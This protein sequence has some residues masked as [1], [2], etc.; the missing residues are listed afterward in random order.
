MVQPLVETISGPSYKWIFGIGSL[1]VGVVL[2]QHLVCEEWIFS[3]V[4]MKHK[5]IG[6]QR[7]SH[8]CHV[9]QNLLVVRLYEAHQ[10]VLVSVLEY[11]EPELWNAFSSLRIVWMKS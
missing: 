2:S 6:S 1:P 9:G 10:D 8:V 7:R 5:A 4:E 11:M 3:E